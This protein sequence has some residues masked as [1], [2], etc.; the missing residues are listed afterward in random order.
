MQNIFLTVVLAMICQS[1][2]TTDPV[3]K[4]APKP[5]LSRADVMTR[6]DTLPDADADRFDIG[7]KPS[8]ATALQLIKEWTEVN[9]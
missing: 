8:D 3:G 9:V 4:V 2:T 7:P 6:A 1:C 5:K